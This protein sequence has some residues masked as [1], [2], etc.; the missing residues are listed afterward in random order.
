M[1]QN[2]IVSSV[3]GWV[4]RRKQGTS[5]T[6]GDE[7]SLRARAQ[8]EYPAS[9]PGPWTPLGRRRRRHERSLRGWTRVP[10]VKSPGPPSLPARCLPAHSRL[11][12]TYITLIAY[13]HEYFVSSPICGTQNSQNLAQPRLLCVAPLKYAPNYWF[14]DWFLVWYFYCLIDWL[15]ERDFVKKPFI[16]RN[17]FLP[18]RLSEPRGILIGEDQV[19][20]A[21]PSN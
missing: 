5:G 3:A 12:E 14:F 15:T 2:K 16:A 9:S 10:S 11:L 4:A 19:R 8:P 18:E 21:V 17:N 7:R 6:V 13:I 20:Y 1:K